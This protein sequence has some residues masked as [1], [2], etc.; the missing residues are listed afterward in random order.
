MHFGIGL[1]KFPT[2][3]TALGTCG[4]L[5]LQKTVQSVICSL[6]IWGGGQT[7][8]TGCAKAQRAAEG[9]AR[10]ALIATGCRR[11]A[12]AVKMVRQGSEQW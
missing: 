11:E 6:I 4:S 10:S 1:A 8:A 9:K 7:V 3:Q 12:R 5:D 2:V